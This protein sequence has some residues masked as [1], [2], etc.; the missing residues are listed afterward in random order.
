MRNPERIH[1]VLD[2]LKNIWEQQPDIRFNQLI[3]N[4]QVEYAEKTGKYKMELWEKGTFRGIE[5]YRKIFTVDLFY[6]EDNDF[7]DFL[8]EKLNSFKK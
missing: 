6:V 4:L 8:Q 2:L 3:H 7:E 5:S 1:V